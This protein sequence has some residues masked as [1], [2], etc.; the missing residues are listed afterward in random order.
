MLCTGIY[1]LSNNVHST[2][3]VRKKIYLSVYSLL[4]YLL[5]AIYVFAKLLRPLVKCWRSMGLRAIVYVHCKKGGVGLTCGL[6]FGMQVSEQITH[7][8]SDNYCSG[9]R[10]RRRTNM[11][12][13][14]SL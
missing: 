11:K 13:E 14:S 8:D 2:S 1:V 4:A 12:E 6:S 10:R 7:M 5:L 9:M 3:C